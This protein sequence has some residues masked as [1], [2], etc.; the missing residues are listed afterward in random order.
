MWW[1]GGMRGVLE[2]AGDAGLVEEPRAPRG[3]G[4]VAV[5]EDLDR[6]VAVEGEVAGAV[7][8][9]HA[10]RGR[11][12]RATRTPTARAAHMPLALASP[13]GVATSRVAPSGGTSAVGKSCAGKSRVVSGM[14]T[15]RDH[16]MV[17]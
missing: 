9:A 3:V 14:T 7:D 11:P 2:L 13:V 8:D 5:L 6:H 12:R 4:R 10:A 17:A 15:L 1:T 16:P